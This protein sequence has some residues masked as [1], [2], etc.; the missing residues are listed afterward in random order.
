MGNVA[1][2]SRELPFIQGARDDV[3]FEQRFHVNKGVVL[4]CG[5]RAGGQA[6]AKALS[7]GCVW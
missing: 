5:E 6:S 3:T 1:Q 4:I 2:R 7:Q